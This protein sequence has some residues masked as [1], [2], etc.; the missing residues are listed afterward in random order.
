[1]QD[2]VHSVAVAGQVMT[3]LSQFPGLK[4]E[5]PFL[6]LARGDS[7]D[8]DVADASSLPLEEEQNTVGS[9][10]VSVQ[11]LTALLLLNDEERT[12][13]LFDR[14]FETANPRFTG[15]FW[16]MRT[17]ITW[18]SESPSPFRSV[19]PSRASSTA[20]AVILPE[21]VKPPMASPKFV[22]VPLAT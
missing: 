1:M 7:R 15:A 12:T 22:V 9:V 17:K 18:S 11:V 13:R 8:S 16:P 14:K 10:P 4:E 21:A 6:E 3:S 20:K 2:E 19:P 5:L